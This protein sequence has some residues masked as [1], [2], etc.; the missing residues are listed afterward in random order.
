MKTNRNEQPKDV[1]DCKM[2]DEFMA[3]TFKFKKN[4]FKINRI[5]TKQKYGSTRKITILGF[6]KFSYTKKSKK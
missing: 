2:I 3:G 4:K 6:I 1:N 5:I